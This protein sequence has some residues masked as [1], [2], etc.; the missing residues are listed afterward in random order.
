MQHQRHRL[1][2]LITNAGLAAV[3]VVFG[4]VWGS[5]TDNVIEM[6]EDHF[7]EEPDIFERK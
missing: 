5:S 1:S 3:L 2:Q 4:T 6:R 7:G